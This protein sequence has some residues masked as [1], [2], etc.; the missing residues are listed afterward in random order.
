M[1]KG[2]VGCEVDGDGAVEGGEIDGFG[3]EEVGSGFGAGVEHHTVDCGVVFK[4][5][6]GN[7]SLV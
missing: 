2:H 1:Y 4:G 5:S 3:L 6:F 7:V